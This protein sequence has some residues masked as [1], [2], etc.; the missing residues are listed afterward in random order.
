[1]QKHS[2]F[3]LLLTLLLVDACG[4]PPIVPDPIDRDP[5]DEIRTAL[6]R[7][8]QR[9][10]RVLAND[11]YGDSASRLVYLDQGWNPGE[12]LW[13]YHADQ[14]SALMP[15]D[16]LVHLEQPDRAAPFIAPEHLTRFRFLNQD[17]TPNNPDA[18]P[19][20]FA[21]R[22]DDVGLTCAAC[23]TGQINY[24]GT[25]LRIEGAPAMF[26]MVGFLRSVSASITATLADDTKLARY[27][28]ATSGRADDAARVTAARA[29]LTSTGQ[30]FES[31]LTANRSS[32]VEGF[33]RLDAIGRIV[34]QT[35]RFTSGPE[36]SIE[37]NA[38]TS[39]PLLWDTPRHDFV[40][41]TGFATNAGVGSLGRNAGEVVGVFGQ[42]Q[43]VRHTTPEEARRGY[44]SSI[45]GH[46]IVSME[47][48][49]FGLRSPVWPESILPPI[50]R[51][52]AARGRAVY[53]TH[54]VSCHALIDREDPMRHVTAMVTGVDVVG[55]DDTSA[56]NL[57][58]AWIP[59]GVLE[60]AVAWDGGTY[61]ARERP[62]RIL[63]DL[64][65]RSLSQ[66]PTAALRATAAA[67]LHGLTETPRQGQ[68]TRST[69]QN[70]TAALLSYKARPLNGIWAAAPYLHNGSVPTLY[71]LMLPVASRPTRFAVGR[72]EYDPRRVGYVSD[73]EVPFVVDTTLVGNSNRGHDYGAVLNDDERWALVEYLKSL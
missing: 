67:M 23:H 6:Q 8:G 51:G 2:R 13:Y 71:D 49:L 43:V 65:S 39:F 54:C 26:D 25:A 59:S 4:S 27:V 28:A 15:Y 33:G 60:G 40:Q 10:G 53:Q 66:Q 50:D 3:A 21:R 37:T 64:V 11:A 48:T 47:N 44:A 62:L 56:R 70:P 61:G 35:I 29:S 19:V 34:N 45:N 7:F 63:G 68:H 16:M 22:G 32:T 41:W 9:G 38:P 73:G 31:Y 18:L 1:M 58:T 36:N 52:L 14:G 69:D 30:W 57:A 72:W 20:G 24:Q 46:A 12:T 17:P 5:F 55:T 42:V